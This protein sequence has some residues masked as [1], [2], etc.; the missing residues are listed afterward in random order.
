MLLYIALIL[1]VVLKSI[2]RGQCSTGWTRHGNSCYHFSHDK[3]DWPNAQFLCNAL[4]G[5]LVEISN[6]EEGQFLE[7]QSKLFHN[8]D[9]QF[10][11]GAS[12]LLFEGEWMWMTSNTRVSTQLIHWAP[13]NPSNSN[14][15]ENC[16][17]FLNDGTWNDAPCS[18]LFHYTCEKEVG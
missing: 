15:N 13:G 9:D 14:S 5:Y 3:E 17:T 12:D 18:L 1:F 16:M 10:W 11:V 8:I 6:A 4:G 2:V 7:N